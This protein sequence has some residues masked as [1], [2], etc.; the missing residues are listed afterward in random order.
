MGNTK[1]HA[2]KYSKNFKNNI[3]IFLKKIKCCISEI[4]YFNVEEVRF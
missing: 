1:I 2:K 3:K 4:Q